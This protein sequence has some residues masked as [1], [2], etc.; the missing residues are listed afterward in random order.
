[1]DSPKNTE[2]VS[3]SLE[4]ISGP[5]FSGKTSEILRRLLIDAE[6]GFRVVYIN[7]KI[8]TRSTGPFSTH[9]PL[10]KERLSGRTNIQFM[11]SDRLTGL[12]ESVLKYDVIGID[13]AQFFPD[14]AKVIPHWVDIHHKKVIVAGLTGDFQRKKFGQLLDLEPMSDRYTKLK[15]YCQPCARSK[16]RK[17]TD[18]L[19]TH[20]IVASEA[21]V[22]VG[23]AESYIPV[24][25]ECYNRLTAE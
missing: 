21:T 1:M 22:Q 17:I 9:N 25:R 15:S 11:G 24:C 20:R 5:M 4:L 10:Y 2:G 13:E 19:F 3:G 8:D 7:H 16:R 23:G 18:A 14:L 6:I 12:Q